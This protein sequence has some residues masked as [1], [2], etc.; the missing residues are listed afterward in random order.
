MSL[1]SKNTS[2]PTDSHDKINNNITDLKSKDKNMDN[3]FI[4]HPLTPYPTTKTNDDYFN[5]IT[6]QFIPYANLKIDTTNLKLEDYKIAI[7]KNGFYKWVGNNRFNKTLIILIILE[8][9]I[10]SNTENFKKFIKSYE[11]FQRII[12]IVDTELKLNVRKVIDR[13]FSENVF[14]VYPICRFCMTIPKHIVVPSRIEINTQPI[15]IEF[16]IK[17]ISKD[18]PQAVWLQAIPGELIKITNE[19]EI[20]GIK[21]DYRRV[22]SQN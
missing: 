21:I 1:S 12:L 5:I 18:D 2:E 8:S 17:T 6:K 4:Y 16:Q 3:T 10:L 11:H 20:T 22:V 14:S 19:T 15:N 7:A 13:E 9:S